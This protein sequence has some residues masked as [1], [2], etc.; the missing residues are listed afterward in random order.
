MVE[1]IVR[2]AKGD[3]EIKEALEYPSPSDTLENHGSLGADFDVF[4]STQP[5]E[6]AD[7]SPKKLKEAHDLSPLNLMKSEPVQE[8]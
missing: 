8:V 2:I 4:E 6:E 1:A 3:L 7:P 5:S